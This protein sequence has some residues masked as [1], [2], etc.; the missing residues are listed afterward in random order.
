MLNA[1]LATILVFVSV[2]LLL[3]LVGLLFNAASLPLGGL[4]E[5]QRFARCVAR[6]RRCDALIEQGSLEPALRQLRAAFYLHAVSSR[7]L[8]SEVANHHTALLSRLIA[9]TSEV[10]GGTV[11]LLSLAKTDRLLTE[12]SDL[13]RRYFAA[14]Q[15]ARRER[16]REMQGQLRSN[17]R[18]LAAALQQLIAEVRA[19]RQ[20][21]RYH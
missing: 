20:P 13:Q 18:E 6:A 2:G 3:Y 5:R 19:A 4:W 21:A 8:A 16:V 11:R 14:R 9:I 7:S 12:R 15:G 10:Q 17:S 1:L